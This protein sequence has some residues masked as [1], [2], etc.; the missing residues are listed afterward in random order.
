M[1][2]FFIFS[3]CEGTAYFMNSN[4]KETI[5]EFSIAFLLQINSPYLTFSFISHLLIS[6]VR[7]Y[8]PSCREGLLTQ[9]GRECRGVTNG[10]GLLTQETSLTMS[11]AEW[12]SP[13]DSHS[14]EFLSSKQKIVYV[15]IHLFVLC[16]CWEIPGPITWKVEN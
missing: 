9:V 15:I 2:F 5:I 3:I 11:N 1:W 4:G 6:D 13:N 14:Q 8:H 12:N 7:N 10:E 16:P